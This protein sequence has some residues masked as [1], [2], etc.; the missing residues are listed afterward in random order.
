MRKL[1]CVAGSVDFGGRSAQLCD[2]LQILKTEASAAKCC[3]LIQ[4]LQVRSR[5]GGYYRPPTRIFYTIWKTTTS[6]NG[7][8]EKNHLPAG[9]TPGL[10]SKSCLGYSGYHSSILPAGSR[11][12]RGLQSVKAKSQT[13]SQWLNSNNS[14]DADSGA[15]IVCT[16]RNR[17]HYQ[18]Q[19]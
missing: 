13:Y 8:H 5:L 15:Q 11:Q 12:S 19:F 6:T 4:K 3:R 16:K 18:N 14:K 10:I 17:S 9:K 1:Y 7:V 2:L